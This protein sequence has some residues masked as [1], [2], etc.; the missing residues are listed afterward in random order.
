VKAWPGV[1]FELFADDPEDVPV[2]AFD[3]SNILIHIRFC[4]DT[5]WRA[6]EILR[7]EIYAVDLA[8][9]YK[10]DNFTVSLCKGV[11]VNPY[12]L[13]KSACFSI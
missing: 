6:Q 7:P 11:H 13:K 1:D 3:F 9:C 2:W 8:G 4:N 12:T 10:V 5:V